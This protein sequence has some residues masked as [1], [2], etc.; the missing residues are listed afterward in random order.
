MV[1]SIIRSGTCFF[2]S[3]AT[4]R[5]VVKKKKDHII[6]PKNLAVFLPREFLKLGAQGLQKVL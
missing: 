6:R 4:P 5:N 3:E 2:I 1:F